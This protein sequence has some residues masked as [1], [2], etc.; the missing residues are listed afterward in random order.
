MIEGHGNH[1]HLYDTLTAD[2]SSNV[3]SKTPP[4]ALLRHLSE[5]LWQLS[6]YPEPD[7]A[8]LRKKL[9]QKWEIHP[10]QLLIT[11]GS[12]EAIYL[13]A[14]TF[15]KSTSLLFFPSFSEYEDACR[16][17]KHHLRFESVANRFQ[18]L[19]GTPNLVWL[20]NPNN[21][22]GA[23]TPPSALR[24]KLSENPGTTFII[25]EA[26]ADLCATFESA[27]PLIKEF[28]NLVVIRSLT[29]LFSIPGLRIGYLVTNEALTRSIKKFLQPWSVN[30]LAQIAG[31]FLI[32]NEADCL[33]N[34]PA[35]LLRSQKWQETLSEI[36]GIEVSPSPCN[37]FLIKLLHKTAFE[38][39]NQLLHHHGILIRDA[40][41]F[42]GLSNR[43][44]RLSCQTEPNNGALTLALKTFLRP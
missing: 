17:H 21:P 9:A 44:F 43:H 13:V 3:A 42:R 32:E 37:F 29:K 14:T 36:P 15:R 35:L 10:S 41:N 19:K 40:S 4:E 18:P 27:I 1:V 24:Q 8:A 26:Y 25:D 23:S 33:P 5:N 2:F 31:S 6:V 12:T 7:A 39:K 30:T 16:L 11:N 20:G 28:N 38:L 22:D 34:I